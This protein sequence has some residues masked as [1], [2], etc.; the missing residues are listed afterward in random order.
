M[1]T[2]KPEISKG[3]MIKKN[4]KQFTITFFNEY[5]QEKESFTFVGNH[6]GAKN[7][8]NNRIKEIKK[9]IKEETLLAA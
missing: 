6:A 8:L 5:T 3:K 7:K 9:Q 1:Q 2:S 4:V